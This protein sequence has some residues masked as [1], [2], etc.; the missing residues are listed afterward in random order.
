MEDVSD[1]ITLQTDRPPRRSSIHGDLTMSTITRRP[2]RP[3]IESAWVPGPPF[4]M[5]LEK[6][7]AMVDAG[8]LTERDN[9]HLI[10]GVLVAK[11]NQN[12]PHATADLLCNAALT[13]IIPAGWHVRP[14]KPVRLPPDSKPEPDQC[15][16]RGSIRDYT[17]PEPTAADVGLI[18][19]VADT[20]LKE[21]RAMAFVYGAAGIPVYWIIDVNARQVEVYTLRQAPAGRQGPGG[22]GKPRVFK[23]GQ[24]MPVVLD[25]VEV[26]QIAVTDILP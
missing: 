1:P 26:G 6:Y 2:P 25:G 7:E 10:N 13:A 15:V 22:Y 17:G 24:S 5:S 9:V 4:R 19:E 14:D 12:G 8:I 21:D 23:D 18:V 11:M 20:S 3:P 16:V